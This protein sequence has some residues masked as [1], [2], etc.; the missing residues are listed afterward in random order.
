MDFSEGNFLFSISCRRQLDVGLGSSRPGVFNGGLRRLRVGDA[1][2]LR[3]IKGQSSK[4][5][6]E[7]TGY[8]NVFKEYP[9][10]FRVRPCRNLP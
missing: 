5:A 6:E 1:A 8:L 3:T 4:E 9:I 2:R 10:Q 7:H